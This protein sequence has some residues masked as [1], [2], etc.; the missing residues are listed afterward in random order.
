MPE[1]EGVIEP[2]IIGASQNVSQPEEETYEP[3]HDRI[4]RF[5]DRIAGWVAFKEAELA[6]TCRLYSPQ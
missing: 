6:K 5:A 1:F 4:E 3:I 2:I